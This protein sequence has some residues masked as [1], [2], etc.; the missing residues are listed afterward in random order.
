MNKLDKELKF[1]N[2]YMEINSGKVSWYKA[3]ELI[4]RLER[5]GWKMPIHETVNDFIKRGGTITKLPYFKHGT[6]FDVN[7]KD[8]RYFANF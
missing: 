7:E 4:N 3:V 5:S 8:C 6:E 2:N 1:V